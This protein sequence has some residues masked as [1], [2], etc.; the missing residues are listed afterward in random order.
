MPNFDVSSVDS[1]YATE[2]AVPQAITVPSSGQRVSL[3]LGEQQLDAKLRVRT[4]PAQEEAAYLIAEVSAPEGV[5]PGGPLDLY[6]DGAYVGKGRFDVDAL[7]QSGLAFGRVQLGTAFGG[8]LAGGLPV[9]RRGR[10]TGVLRKG[11][12][13]RRERRDCGQ[14]K[15][16]ANLVIHGVV[17]SVTSGRPI[18]PDIAK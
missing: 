1:A 7:A 4:S 6:R 12:R 17:L 5:W 16:N 11:G 10:K 8:R 15:G 18:R 3:T 14:Q 13:R 9:G 2:F